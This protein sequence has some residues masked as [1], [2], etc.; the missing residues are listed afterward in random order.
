MSTEIKNIDTISNN[1]LLEL[2]ALLNEI[3]KSITHDY[4]HVSEHL[5]SVL[6]DTIQKLQQ[7]INQE[8]DKRDI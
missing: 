5:P 1:N 4:I 2:L 7:D 3:D 8:C 6:I